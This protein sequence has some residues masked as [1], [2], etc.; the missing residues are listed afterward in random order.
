MQDGV[1]FIFKTLIKVPIYIAI[2]FMCFNIFAFTTIYFKA[3]GFSYVLMQTVV[4]NNY[5][6][7]NEAIQLENYVAQNFCV[8]AGGDSYTSPLTGRT[9]TQIGS[10][11]GLGVDDS[12]MVKNA[13]IEISDG[14]Q[15]RQY[16]ATKTISLNLEYEMILPLMPNEQS[17]DPEE[18]AVVG[19]VE[20]VD[21]NGVAIANEIPDALDTADLVAR[22]NTVRDAANPAGGLVRVPIK[23]SYTVPG[24]KFYPDMA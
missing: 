2:A 23:I 16:G 18:G 20:M 9:A 3:L 24:L 8:P 1:Q 6:P 5:I 21:V 15:R 19:Y 17:I 10:A 22:Q 14:N 11:V 4:E 7:T 12:L 13:T